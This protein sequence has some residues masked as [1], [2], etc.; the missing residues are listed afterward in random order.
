MITTAV[1]LADTGEQWE[2]LI[3]RL[4]VRQVS[5]IAISIDTSVQLPAELLAA[6]DRRPAA[7]HLPR[8]ARWLT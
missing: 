4:D 1:T 5:G 2:Q 8:H 7:H 6:A 3:A